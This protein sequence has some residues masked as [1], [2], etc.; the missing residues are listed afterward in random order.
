MLKDSIIPVFTKFFKDHFM[1]DV[2]VE[3]VPA[4]SPLFTVKICDG[5]R[6]Q[7]LLIIYVNDR[8]GN[9]P[10]LNV[11][12]Y[13]G[14]GETYLREMMK[15]AK[16]ADDHYARVHNMFK[17]VHEKIAVFKMTQNEPEENIFDFFKS[18]RVN[19]VNDFNKLCGSRITEFKS[20]LGST[21]ISHDFVFTI[22]KGEL[23]LDLRFVYS[24]SY[25]DKIISS[26]PQLLANNPSYYEDLEKELYHS[27]RV[28]I[29]NKIRQN[30][31]ITLNPKEVLDEDIVRYVQVL[32]MTKI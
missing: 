32:E 21:S 23:H 6:E 29:I 4:V 13:D 31:K 12:H 3:E 28:S 1:V 11:Y 10:I 7:H 27:S 24:V 9:L 8:S 30:L 19:N 18:Y 2:I 25:S 14:D 17:S 16:R 26:H 22:Y 5:K 20:G 15:K